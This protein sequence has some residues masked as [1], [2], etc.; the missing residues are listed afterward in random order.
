MK[1]RLLILIC[2]I[3]LF[4]SC[5]DEQEYDNTKRGNF[6]ALWQILD[7]RYCFFE[8]K[9]IDWNAIYDKYSIRI[10]ETMSQDAFFSMM[11]EMLTELKDGHVN[12]SA[13][14]DLGRFWGWYEDFPRNFDSNLLYDNYLGT[15]YMIASGLKYKILDDNVGYIYYESFS[16]GIG[17]GNLSQVIDRL[18]LCS[19]IIIDVRSNGGG[20]LT[21]VDKIV[22]RFVNEKT[23]VGYIM[24]KTGKGH[25]DF[26][27][28][29]K[30]YIEPYDGLR[31]QKNVVVLA[32][33]GSYSATNDFVNAMKYAPNAII[34]G[35]RTGG[36]SGLPFSSELP[37]GWNVRFSA[38]PM[39][40]REM[41]HLEFGIEPDLY[42]EMNELERL[43]G[44][45]SMIEKAREYLRST[46]DAL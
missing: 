14:H 32:N 40:N 34:M 20:Q 5:F 3:P 33:R 1:Y 31:Y 25:N 26:S 4:F 28:P 15:N 30:K 45:D 38:C 23:H 17:D 18:S 21:N 22:A 10:D 9:D 37:N 46:G 11:A 36:G 39:L 41:K 6:D 12:L 24:H 43:A 35:D 13:S 42:V 29:F 7:E 44:K 2:C 8:Y 16:D 19:G 27:K